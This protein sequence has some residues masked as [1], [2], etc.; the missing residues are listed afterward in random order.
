MSNSPAFK[1]GRINQLALENRLV[2]APM[3]RISASKT[4]VP[5]ERMQRYYTRF[6]K[7]GFGAVITE[8]I[9]IDD[10]WSQ[11]YDF[12]A[13]LINNEQVQGWRTITESLHMNGSKV[14]AQ[15]QHSGALSQGNIYRSNTVAPSA[16]QPKG[17]QLEFYHGKGDYNVPLELS[18]DN[19][20]DIIHSFAVAA[21][22]AVNEAGFDGV[23]IHG[24]NGYLLDQFFT[25]YT[26]QRSDHWGG[27]IASRLSLI[28]EV[29]HAVRQSVGPN[30]VVGVR[31]SQAKVNDFHHK[32]KEGKEGAETVFSLLATSGVDYVH[33]T[34]YEAWRPTFEDSPHSLVEIARKVA[35]ELIIIANGGTDNMEKAD[36]VLKLGADYIA[37]G[38]SAL[39]NPDWPE[40]VESGKTLREFDSGILA[41]FANVKE[42]ELTQ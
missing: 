5:G 27:D 21:S 26:N 16:I 33:I 7:G 19:I 22:R 37:I 15:I 40:R 11:T 3:T 10:E 34:E 24:A 29:I 42:S 32:W 18:E 25:D 41:P 38:K 9:Y 1:S 4:G 28:L 14:I 35:P 17:E 12:Q 6:A 30:T 23:E 31:I 2:V 13:G 39:A 36:K 8:G 20:Q